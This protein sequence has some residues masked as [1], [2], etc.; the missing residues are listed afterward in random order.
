V[1]SK[2]KT[3]ERQLVI[4]KINDIQQKE[5]ILKGNIIFKMIPKKIFTLA[6]FESFD[7]FFMVFSLKKKTLNLVF[8]IIYNDLLD[9]DRDI[10]SITESLNS[11]KQD[12][13]EVENS[14][15]LINFLSNLLDTLIR[16]YLELQTIEIYLS[17]LNSEEFK[18]SKSAGFWNYISAASSYIENL[19]SIIKE[20]NFSVKYQYESLKSICGTINEEFLRFKKSLRDL[21][22]RRHS[23]SNEQTNE[24]AENLIDE[25]KEK[26]E[27]N[28]EN[29]P[30]IE[31]S[32]TLLFNLLHIFLGM[33]KEKQQIYSTNK[34]KIPE[35]IKESISLFKHAKKNIEKFEEKFLLEIPYADSSKIFEVDNNYF[36]AI[37]SDKKNFENP[38]PKA[39]E[40]IEA[41]NIYNKFSNCAENLNKVFVYLQALVEKYEK[42]KEKEKANNNEDNNKRKSSFDNEDD[43]DLEE[44]ERDKLGTKYNPILPVSEWDLICRECYIELESIIKLREDLTSAEN[45]LKAKVIDFILF[46]IEF[47]FNFLFDF[48]LFFCRN[49]R[50]L[51]LKIS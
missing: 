22:R 41:V 40:L 1:N 26:A 30:I 29:Y 28:S 34:N 11:Y 7:K 12:D 6:S 4:Q 2:I 16:F 51:I 10:L 17:T 39:E 15:T 35:I 20:D 13:L 19:I 48:Y 14:K 42:E 8:N 3:L 50:I 23:I 25:Y 24:E 38:E 46:F 32:E 44:L 5:S 45:K 37:K 43:L 49:W 9:K 36:Q 27:F 31:Y 47:F 18:E 33:K 21:I